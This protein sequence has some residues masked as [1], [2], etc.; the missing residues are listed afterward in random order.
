MAKLDG[1]RRRDPM[2]ARKKQPARR[3]CRWWGA[4]W[5]RVFM[6]FGTDTGIDLVVIELYADL[7]PDLRK[8]PRAVHG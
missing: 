2:S 3:D 7:V 4:G 8:L 5:P 6:T 1:E